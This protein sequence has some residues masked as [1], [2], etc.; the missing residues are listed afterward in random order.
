MVL[1]DLEERATS[2]FRVVDSRKC[3]Q[4]WAPTITL[5]NF[6]WNILHFTVSYAASVCFKT[7][8]IV[9]WQLRIMFWIIQA[10]DLV[11]PTVFIIKLKHIVLGTESLLVIGIKRKKKYVTWVEPGGKSCSKPVS[12]EV[13]IVCE[14]NRF[15]PRSA[16]L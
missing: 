16:V 1:N 14:E 15:C 11:H 3:L 12:P 10:L 13:F 9:S 2:V 6:Q 5:H 4:F 7:Y 8:F